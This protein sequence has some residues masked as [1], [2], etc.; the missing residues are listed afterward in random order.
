MADTQT[1][2]P[3][4]LDDMV[5]QTMQKTIDEKLPKML[6]DAVEKATRESIEDAFRWGDTRNAIRD[7][8]DSI[9][10]PAIENVNVNNLNTKLTQVL[11]EVFEQ[12]S[13]ADT[14]NI[15]ENFAGL[16]IRDDGP[17]KASELLKLFAEQCASAIDCTGREVNF[18]CSE[19]QYEDFEVE[20]EINE[21]QYNYNYSRSMQDA[22]LE[23]RI[24]D[25]YATDEEAENRMCRELRLWR[26]DNIDEPNQ[27]RVSA[28][29][30]PEVAI[31]D[32]RRMSPLDIALLRMDH[33]SV[34]LLDDLNYRNECIEMTP[35]ST[36]EV[37]VE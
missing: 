9:L 24:R 30:I 5:R 2:Q 17:I 8:V 3:M 14:R 25:D 19:P 37:T 10:I 35:E 20:A 33:G 11:N 34:R 12:T 29:S 22:I 31:R 23:L 21:L 16:M 36:P 7:C 26:L 32:L 15:I 1:T 6:E 13:A 4:T 28:N 18:E 27:W